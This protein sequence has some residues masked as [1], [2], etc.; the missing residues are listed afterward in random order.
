MQDIYHT[1]VAVTMYVK[2]LWGL[3]NL[4]TCG[5]EKYLL[6]TGW[7]RRDT[8]LCMYK[9]AMEFLNLFFYDC[10]DCNS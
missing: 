3:P 4:S 8:F 2:I 9:L 6:K 5:L 7:M 1:N 10:N